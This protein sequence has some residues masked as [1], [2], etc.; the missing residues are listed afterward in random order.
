[1]HRDCGADGMIEKLGRTSGSHGHEP[2]RPAPG[3]C[4]P[5]TQIIKLEYI[6]LGPARHIPDRGRVGVPSSR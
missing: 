6:A 4:Y 3:D 1:M 5:R 2:V